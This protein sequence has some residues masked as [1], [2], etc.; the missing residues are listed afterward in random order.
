M[1]VSSG[2]NLKPHKFEWDPRMKSFPVIL[3]L[4]TEIHQAKVEEWDEIKALV[5]PS[6]PGA[7]QE[8]KFSSGLPN[9][10]ISPIMTNHNPVNFQP[11]YYVMK[12]ADIFPVDI[13]INSNDPSHFIK[14][15]RYIKK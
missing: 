5:I 1:F 2:L 7:D 9:L 13:D 11:L 6:I 12:V 15:L 4:F 3:S 14:R 8:T 10:T